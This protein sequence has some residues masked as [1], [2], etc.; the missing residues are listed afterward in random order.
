M[1]GRL[2]D[3]T[4]GALN[5]T[6]DEKNHVGA[7]WLNNDGTISIKLNPFIVLSAS[8]DLVMTLFTSSYRSKQ[9]K[10]EVENEGT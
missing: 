1:S 5:K 7:A 10:E 9:K 3:Y 6:T 8:P 4:L 2:P